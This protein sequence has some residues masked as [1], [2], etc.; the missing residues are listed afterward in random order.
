MMVMQF[1]AVGWFSLS[2][3]DLGY[4]IVT[5]GASASASLHVTTQES[6]VVNIQ[7]KM[8]IGLS[9]NVV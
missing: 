2:S 7:N 9:K 4:V 8:L 3:N 1:A 6:Q 5:C